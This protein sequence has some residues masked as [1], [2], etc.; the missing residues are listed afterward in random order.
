M[1]ASHGDDIAPL[2]PVAFSPDGRMV[3]TGGYRIML[4]DLSGNR[5]HTFDRTQGSAW[6]LA[7]AP[8]G[9]T[10]AS[11]TESAVR[12]WDVMTGKLRTHVRYPG[13]ALIV[14]YSPQGKLLAAGHDG[15]LRDVADGQAVDDGQVVSRVKWNVS[16]HGSPYSVDGSMFIE[17]VTIAEAQVE[18]RL[19]QTQMGQEI[20]RFTKYLGYTRY[21]V[22][23][24]V[25]RDRMRLAV[26]DE[27]GRIV[28]WLA[29][30]R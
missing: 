12:Q 30:A 14:C 11:A 19:R 6:S 4:W 13:D 9:K 1:K 16:N 2:F 26:S 8:D 22:G 29:T 21:I 28:V 5:I 3:A 25:S 10:L 27:H 23:M 17:P 7:F 18:F 20:R 15:R 24:A